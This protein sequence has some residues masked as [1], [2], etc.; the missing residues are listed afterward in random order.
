M[1]G[2]SASES[3]HLALSDND[4]TGES[5]AEVL[6]PLSTTGYTPSP[7]D[8]FTPVK[9]ARPL[10]SCTHFNSCVNYGEFSHGIGAHRDIEM[11]K[12]VEG[13]NYLSVRGFGSVEHNK[14]CL[15]RY[16]FD[17]Y[18]KSWDYYSFFPDNIF[19][20]DTPPQHVLGSP[21]PHLP[22][23]LRVRPERF[24]DFL[25]YT[26]RFLRM[27]FR[28]SKASFLGTVSCPVSGF[29][30]GEFPG[31]Y[32]LYDLVEDGLSDSGRRTVV[33]IDSTERFSG[34][35]TKN[36][37]HTMNPPIPCTHLSTVTPSDLPPPHIPRS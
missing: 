19:L 16:V 14:D 26:A 12:T 17:S 21:S 27:S 9:T 24:S 25:R 33:V 18:E 10:R 23:A 34:L 4:Y 1:R 36:S 5:G 31:F 6:H 15:S 28:A 8:F 20:R 2:T 30:C 22:P 7:D 11:L 35:R 37:P 32:E 3:P 13:D 29:I